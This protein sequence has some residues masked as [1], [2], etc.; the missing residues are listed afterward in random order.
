MAPTR[1]ARPSLGC[2]ARLTQTRP[3]SGVGCGR[4][5]FRGD[6]AGIGYTDDSSGGDDYELVF[7]VP[8]ANSDVVE[9]IAKECDVPVTA[10]GKVETC[11]LWEGEN[12]SKMG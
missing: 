8:H 12:S 9:A 11:F 5:P 10:I 7:C 4:S 2:A 6:T 1:C 3:P